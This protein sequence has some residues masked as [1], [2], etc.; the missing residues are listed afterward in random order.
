[1]T[2]FCGITQSYELNVFSMPIF[3]CYCRFVIFSPL[4]S[5]LK[6]YD[7]LK[8]VGVAG[9]INM[10]VMV[11]SS[12][13]QTEENDDSFNDSIEKLHFIVLCFR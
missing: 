11:A 10:N 13:L 12:G 8:L 4:E 9:C 6:I 2:K 5:H 1:M 3:Q 7:K